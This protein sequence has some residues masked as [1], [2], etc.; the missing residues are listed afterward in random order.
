LFTDGF[1][2]QLGWTR[3]HAGHWRYLLVNKTSAFTPKNIIW[4]ESQMRKWK[5]SMHT[6]KCCE[7]IQHDSESDRKEDFP[8]K[9]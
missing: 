8:E 2:T 6:D 1:T 7:R 3:F 4:G 5:V 9:K